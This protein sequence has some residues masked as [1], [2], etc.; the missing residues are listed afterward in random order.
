MRR[1]GHRGIWGCLLA[2]MLVLAI[3]GDRQARADDDEESDHDRA[4]GAVHRGEVLPLE[5]MLAAIRSQIQGEIVGL[6]L[7]R[8][9]GAWIYEFKVI[10]PSG[11]FVKIDA[12]AKTGKI[13]KMDDD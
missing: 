7:E 3:I 9:D 8:E 5:Q 1:T 13:L 10:D 12:D 2:A 11:R 4:L 6:E